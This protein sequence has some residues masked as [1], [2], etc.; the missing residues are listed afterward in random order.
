MFSEETDR[1]LIRAARIAAELD[2]IK[3]HQQ[4]KSAHY[5]HQQ[6]PQQQQYKWIYS[7]PP[8]INHPSGCTS[9]PPSLHEYHQILPPPPSINQ[10]QQHPQITQSQIYAKVD[11]IRKH[12][13]RKEKDNNNIVSVYQVPKPRC[14]ILI[15]QQQQQ[16]Q[17]LSSDYH[18]LRKA[19]STPDAFFDNNNDYVEYGTIRRI[20]PP[21][22]NTIQRSMT[23][24]TTITPVPTP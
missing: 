19:I 8:R 24:K 23:N 10:Q 18:Q 14:P 17:L 4:Q 5:Y 13:Y 7:T 2:A 12:R 20:Q 16:Q 6:Q 21:I 9:L 3:N 22:F 15:S 11:L 1:K